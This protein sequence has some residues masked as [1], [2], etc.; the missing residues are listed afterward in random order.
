VGTYSRLDLYTHCRIAELEGRFLVIR[1]FLVHREV[2]QAK[3]RFAEIG[4]EY[5]DSNVKCLKLLVPL[6]SW[7]AVVLRSLIGGALRRFTLFSGH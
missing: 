2:I 7:L 5:F 6:K 4:K 3:R 1:V